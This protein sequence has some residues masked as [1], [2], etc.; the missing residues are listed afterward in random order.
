MQIP[1]TND[2]EI[3]TPDPGDIERSLVE[4]LR[5]E[6]GDPEITGSDNFLDVGGHSLTF[7]KLNQFLGDSFGV[8]L[9]M[10]TTYEE[11]LNVAATK[12]QPVESATPA[13]R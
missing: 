1:G 5:D 11:P 8:V 6:L 3:R 9:D 13:T 4:W 7:S 2:G 10:R 12:I